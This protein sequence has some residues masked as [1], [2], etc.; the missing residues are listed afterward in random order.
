MGGPTKLSY[1]HEP[2][3]CTPE[4]AAKFMVGRKRI[5]IMT[6]A[7]VS[8]ASGIPTFR[9]QEGFWKQRYS[10]AGETDPQSILT[11]GFFKEHPEAVWQ[12]HVDFY[13]IMEK[14]TVKPNAGHYAIR[15]FQ[16]YCITSSGKN[17]VETMLMTQNIDD[18]HNILIK[19]SKVLSTTPDPFMAEEHQG[20]PAFTP[21]GYDIHG[22][23][24]YMHCS[25]ESEE[26][27]KIFKKV[28]TLA[29]FLEH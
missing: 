20:V 9:Y 19:E 1:D 14:P 24:N 5:T 21:H 3:V 23:V 11:K 22:N 13:K 29:T 8:A 12:W 15:D 26:H 2:Q 16:E 4:E 7:G 6:G 18:L 28:P 17:K 27:S 25:D 10:Y